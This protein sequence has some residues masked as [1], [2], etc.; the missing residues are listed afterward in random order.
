MI[1]STLCTFFLRFA[2]PVVFTAL[3]AACVTYTPGQIGG[4]SSLDLCELRVN[5]GVNLSAETRRALQDELQRRSDDCRSHAAVIAERRAEALHR[6]MY[7]QV[8]P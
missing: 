3:T 5:Q 6:D 2:V 1:M 4:L 8:D 7:G